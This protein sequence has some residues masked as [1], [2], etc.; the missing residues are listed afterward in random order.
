MPSKNVAFVGGSAVILLLAVGA[1]AWF[2]RLRPH[3][4]LPQEITTPNSQPAEP[5]NPSHSDNPDNTTNNP[6]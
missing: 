1:G 3:K 6:S 4:K 5:D 2:F